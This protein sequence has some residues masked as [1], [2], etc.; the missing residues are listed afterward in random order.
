MS[1]LISSTH[2]LDGR[3]ISQQI[4]QE[5]RSRINTL[6]AKGRAP[7]LAVVLIGNDPA[8]QIY[9]R[10][11][12]KTCHELGITSIDR[13][14]DQDIS[15]TELLALIGELNRDPNVDGIL[16]QSP[17]PPQIE[18]KEILLAIDPGK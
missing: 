16:V 18:E 1:R 3:R 9:V 4:Q 13:T 6:Q 12:I 10:N 15:Q 5:L 14:P 2:V 11:K 8:S 17:L 7:A